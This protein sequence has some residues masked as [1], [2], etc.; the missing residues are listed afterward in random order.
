MGTLAL[1][2]QLLVKVAGSTHF[3]V[4]FCQ[5]WEKGLNILPA[6]ERVAGPVEGL[7]KAILEGNI[8]TPCPSP[9]PDN[10]PKAG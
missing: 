3:P 8:A 9:S 7:R 1:P 4:F 10:S 2:A 5:L 6:S